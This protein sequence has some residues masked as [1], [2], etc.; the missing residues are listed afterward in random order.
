ML[1]TASLVLAVLALAV[2]TA[3]ART[4]SPKLVV[5]DISPLVVRGGHFAPR[6]L[7]AVTAVYE[8]P[9]VKHVR[10]SSSGT[11]RVKF[12]FSIENCAR[13]RVTARGGQGSRAL[14]R[15][16]VEEC[17]TPVAP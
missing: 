10:A 9:H 16:P 11:F 6:E 13:F 5:P 12:R 17:G 7:V 8:G 15:S 4:P 2:T 14:Y 3:S 1:R